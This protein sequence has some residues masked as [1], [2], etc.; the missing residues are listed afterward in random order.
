MLDH[1]ILGTLALR[2]M[3]GYDLGK[4][5]DGPGRFIGYRV[6][7]PQVYRTLVKLAERGL[8]D[9]EVDP[10]EGRPDAK[11]YRLTAIGRQAL[12]DWAHGPYDPAPRPMDPDFMLRFLF[13]GIFGPEVA[14]RL[15]RTEL[16]YRRA[17]QHDP[18]TI[19]ELI[20]DSDPIAE[21]DP[22]W[23]ARIMRTAHENGRD[24]MDGY[25]AWLETVLAEY[26]DA[27]VAAR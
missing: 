15:L 11:V 18:M 27:A 13:A 19:D 2:P 1:V 16:E 26:E 22:A 4:R 7:R 14:V 10:R 25:I 12:L 9:F 20:A 24:S 23:A 3:S 8:V 21:I 5:M 17:Q 6:S